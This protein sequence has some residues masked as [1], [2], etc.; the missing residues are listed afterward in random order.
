MDSSIEFAE[1]KREL[2]LA[3]RYALLAYLDE[4]IKANV[5]KS[6]LN[7]DELGKILETER[8]RDWNIFVGSLV[9]KKIVVDHIGRYIRKPPEIPRSCRKMDL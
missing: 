9:S 2:M 5:M 4:A 8:N 6:D 1:H 7:K 3:W